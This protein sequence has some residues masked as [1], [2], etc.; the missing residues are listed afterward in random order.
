MTTNKSFIPYNHYKYTTLKYGFKKENIKNNTKKNNF[1]KFLKKLFTREKNP[2]GV[3]GD[4]DATYDD[5]NV[6][7]EENV[8]ISS[9]LQEEQ[10]LELSH[11]WKANILYNIYTYTYIYVYT[12][13]Y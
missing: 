9:A 4:D 6:N 7:D 2:N 12:Y 13:I 5:Y 1:P 8:K 3:Y 10:A 11:S